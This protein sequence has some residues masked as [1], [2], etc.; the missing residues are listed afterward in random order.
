MFKK[1]AI[2]FVFGT[3]AGQAAI[4]QDTTEIVDASEAPVVIDGAE[5]PVSPEVTGGWVH[6]PGTMG[7]YEGYFTGPDD[8]Y[9]IDYACGPG[10]SS[11]GFRAKGLHLDAGESTLSVDGTEFASGNT[12]YNSKWD[13]TSFSARFENNWSD[14]LK[15]RHNA[16]LNA[17]SMGREMTWVTPSNEVFKMSLIGSYD[18][19]A[20]LVD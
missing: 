10:Y 13:A 3:L 8:A 19:V 15:D 16:M 1:T 11:V 7:Q 5:P 17:L 18:I 2:V 20:C 14:D 12:T 4:A 9:G 6:A